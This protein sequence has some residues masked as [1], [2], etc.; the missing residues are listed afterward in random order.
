[1]CGLT[2]GQLHSGTV[3]GALAWQGGRFAPPL[4]PPRAEGSCPLHAP[5]ELRSCDLVAALKCAAAHHRLS[6]AAWSTGVDR[7]RAARGCMAKIGKQDAIRQRKT[8]A[9]EA[10]V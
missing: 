5:R 9:G 6:L 3:S 2:A 4:H 1:M 10:A 8:A 7:K